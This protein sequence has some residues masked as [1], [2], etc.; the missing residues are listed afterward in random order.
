MNYAAQQ[1]IIDAYGE[2]ALLTIADRDGDNV[3]DALIVDRALTRATSEIDAA[4]RNRYVTPLVTVPEDIR[5]VAVDMARYFLAGTPGA[6]DDEIRTR[7]EDARKTLDAYANGKRQL[8]APPVSQPASGQIV[9]SAKS[10]VFGDGALGG[11][12]KGGTR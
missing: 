12:T 8:D 7:Y 1:D 3:I 5:A 10:S 6:S 9:I 11:F 2:D 4:F